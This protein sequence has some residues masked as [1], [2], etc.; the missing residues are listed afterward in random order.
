MSIASAADRTRSPLT[1][2]IAF[3]SRSRW[4]RDC[5]AIRRRQ[6]RQCAIPT[7]VV[8]SAIL[9]PVT[10]I[11]RGRCGTTWSI[12]IEMLIRSATVQVHWLRNSF[13]L[14]CLAPSSTRS[15]FGAGRADLRPVRL[16]IGPRSARKGS[17]PE[18]P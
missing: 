14:I 7:S 3:R 13:Q 17:R 5:C 12:P 15:L 16:R 1:T 18:A 6:C 4:R 9:V 2:L 8:G 10:K 11:A